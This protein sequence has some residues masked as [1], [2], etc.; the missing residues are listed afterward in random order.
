MADDAEKIPDK[1]GRLGI[2]AR[3][4][5]ALVFLVLFAIAV[6]LIGGAVSYIIYNYYPRYASYIPYVVAGVKAVLGLVG[7][8]VVYKVLLTVVD[9]YER[10]DLGK[11]ELIK[12]ALRVLLY[13][14]L[15]SIVLVSFGHPLG[16]SLSQALAGGAIGG[17]IIGLAVQTIATAVLA[18]FLI[19]TSRTMVPGELLMIHSTT[20][21]DITCRVIR[22]SM[23]FTEVMSQYGNRMRLPNGLLLSSTT[24]AKLRSND[25]FS[26]PLQIVLN[27]DVPAEKVAKRAGALLE[28]DFKEMKHTLPQIYLSAKGAGT[29]TF[30]VIISF[31]NFTDV[32]PLVDYANK[33]F[34]D[35][36]WSLKK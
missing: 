27:A 33:A 18:G 35:A 31:N 4:I 3:Y 1:A 7:A 28:K 29:N 11:N 30:T 20:L 34:D 6:L 22:V 16:I 5:V 17:I 13:I 25:T 19:S 14:A 26:Y 15:V 36:Y 21:G 32:N 12:L 9:A 23:L 24:F 8:Y 2:V 10:K